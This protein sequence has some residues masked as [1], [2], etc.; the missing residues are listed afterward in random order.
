MTKNTSTFQTQHV[1]RLSL[2]GAAA[3][4]A[5]P[6]AMTQPNLLTISLLV[7]LLALLTVMGVTARPTSSGSNH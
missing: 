7:L 1:L 6:V 4:L 5:V 2:A 3:V